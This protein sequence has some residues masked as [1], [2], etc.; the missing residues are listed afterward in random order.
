MKVPKMLNKHFLAE[1]MS[2]VIY[3]FKVLKSFKSLDC[4]SCIFLAVVNYKEYMKNILN[5]KY[6]IRHIN[7]NQHDLLLQKMINHLLINQ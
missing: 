4:P 2:T 5:K 3:I 1:N 6:I 7:I